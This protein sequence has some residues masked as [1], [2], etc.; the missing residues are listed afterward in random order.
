MDP[1]LNED[2]DAPRSLPVSV[3]GGD[4]SG[5]NIVAVMSEFV[6]VASD[7]SKTK[8]PE[9]NECWLKQP[10]CTAERSLPSSTLPA[11]G[12]ASEESARRRPLEGYAPS[13]L[14]TRD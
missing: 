6:A 13:E 14:S 2:E 5:V 3:A 11:G 12:S 10:A 1:V 7:G 9:L 4:A 8:S